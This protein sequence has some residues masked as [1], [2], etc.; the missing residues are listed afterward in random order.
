MIKA[1]SLLFLLLWNDSQICIEKIIHSFLESALYTQTTQR[2]DYQH[3]KNG[4]SKFVKGNQPPA[5]KKV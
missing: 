5:A 2:L 3:S 1:K 4:L